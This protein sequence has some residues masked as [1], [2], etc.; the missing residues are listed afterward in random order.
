MSPLM[1]LKNIHFSISNQQIINDITLTINPGDFIVMLGSNGSGKST[2]LKL[3][4]Q[5]YQPT[6]GEII[7]NDQ[8]IKQY[9][10]HILQKKIVTLT[11]FISDSIFVDLT[12]EENALLIESAYH[13]KKLNRKKLIA[14]LP[15]YLS[16]FNPKLSTA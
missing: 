7:F 5:T 14:A 13:T 2:L 1:Q 12:I 15:N 6:S 8:P 11:Q 10:Q 4:N 9:T 3:I 16:Q